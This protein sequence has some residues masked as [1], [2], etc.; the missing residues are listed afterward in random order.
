MGETAATAAG[1]VDRR[2]P[3]ITAATAAPISTRPRRAAAVEECAGGLQLSD[4]EAYDD[5]LQGLAKISGETERYVER[6]G[7]NKQLC[8]ADALDRYAEA[9]DKVAPRLPPALRGVPAIVASAA[10]RA[11]TAT[12]RNAAA[13]VL[14]AAIASIHAVVHKTIALMR[15]ADS[16]AKS[17]ATRGGDLVAHTLS[18]AA[19]ALERADTL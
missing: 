19:S 5:A 3:A 11:R 14:R 4:V 15:A 9:L 13:H 6:C 16:D 17:V 12:T 2:A 10:H 1:T 18:A 7:C 8:I